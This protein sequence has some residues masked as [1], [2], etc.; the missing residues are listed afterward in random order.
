MAARTVN[1]NDIEEEK[2]LIA[3]LDYL[4]KQRDIAQQRLR[5]VRNRMNTNKPMVSW[6]NSVWPI[7]ADVNSMVFAES[8]CQ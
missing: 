3:Q 2:S 1:A 8:D 5:E 6:D 7:V 4:D